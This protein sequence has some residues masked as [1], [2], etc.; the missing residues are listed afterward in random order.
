MVGRQKWKDLEVSVIR[1]YEVKF[2][3]SQYK[4]FL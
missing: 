2:P 1:V 3:K 4:C